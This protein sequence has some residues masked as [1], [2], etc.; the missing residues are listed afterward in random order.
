MKKE[1]GFSLIE[2]LVVIS[3]IGVLATI[4]IGGISNARQSARDARRKADLQQIGTALQMWALDHGDMKESLHA[5]GCGA[6]NASLHN[7]A[8]LGGSYIEKHS[9]LHY[10]NRS[11]LNCLVDE[12][13]LPVEIYD[14]HTGYTGGN[15][16]PEND[17]HRYMKTSC[18]TGTYLYTKLEN[19]PQ[20]A[21]AADHTCIPTAD[22]TWGYN[23]VIKI[24]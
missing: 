19:Q 12:G 2:L 23:F 1:K 11:V 17:I 4:I 13:Y 6:S 16:T 22:T 21:T 8:F 9:F 15:Q 10:H 5:A 24:D 18:E 3:I 7:G 20:D 14:P